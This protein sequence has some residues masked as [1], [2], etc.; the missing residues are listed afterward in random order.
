MSIFVKEHVCSLV[1][2][3]F[4]HRIS[5]VLLPFIIINVIYELCK[6]FT[7]PI[8]SYLE[9]PFKIDTGGRLEADVLQ[10]LQE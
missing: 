7:N 8:Y 4:L 5:Y 3:L 1:T 6:I 9:L 2:S 10:D